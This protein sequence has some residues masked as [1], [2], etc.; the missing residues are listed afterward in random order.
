MVGTKIGK[1]IILYEDLLFKS[2]KTM[3]KISIAL[4]INPYSGGTTG[5]PKNVNYFDGFGYLVSSTA[6]K[7][8]DIT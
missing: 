4:A 3:P 1:G 8:E 5:A 2:P 7:T 6:R